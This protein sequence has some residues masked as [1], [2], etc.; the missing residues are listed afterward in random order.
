MMVWLCVTSI[1]LTNQEPITM[2]IQK[3]LNLVQI[4]TLDINNI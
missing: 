4:M 3:H 2:N 1:E